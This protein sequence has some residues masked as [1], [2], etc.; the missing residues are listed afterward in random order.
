MD[1]TEETNETEES[2]GADL[3]ARPA[4]KD[5]KTEEGTDGA[6]PAAPVASTESILDGTLDIPNEELTAAI[7]TA[8]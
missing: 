5:G 2:K 7:F 8:K 6:L 4:E 3:G 1:H